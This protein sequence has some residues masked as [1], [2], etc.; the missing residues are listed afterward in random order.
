MTSLR[1]SCN[2]T[3][4][5]LP[6]QPMYVGGWASDAQLSEYP[7]PIPPATGKHMSVL[8]SRPM[9]NA[10][11]QHM[12]TSEDREPL[13]MKLQRR[14]SCAG[15][16]LFGCLLQEHGPE[17]GTRSC[18]HISMTRI[19]ARILMPRGGLYS[20]LASITPQWRCEGSCLTI[21]GLDSSLR[22]VD[23]T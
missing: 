15:A 19:I 2:N 21:R 5:I 8:V 20:I 23:A 6:L 11:C 13:A 9:S 17:N 10:S 7:Y 4:P 14:P 18:G 3:M 12:L 1:M 22:S 16:R